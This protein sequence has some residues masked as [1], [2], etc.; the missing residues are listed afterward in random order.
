MANYY[1]SLGVSKG[2]SDK[3]IRQA[4]RKLARQYHPDLNPGDKEAEE[5]FKR[6]NEAHEI[7]SDPES[8]KKYDR[9]GDSW[10]HADQFG[11]GR[12]GGPSQWTYRSGDLG[13]GTSG[14]LDDIIGRFDNF[15]GPSGGRRRSA[16][17]RAEVQVTVSLE[18]AF[19]GTKRH[20]TVTSMDQARR[21]EVTIPPGVDT[22][23]VVNVS[24][25]D[26][27]RL[28]LKV[29]VTPHARF[30]RRGRDL[31]TEAEVAL[32]DA[33]LGAETEVQTLKGRVRL[34]VPARSQNGQRIRLAA[35]GM[36]KLGEPSVTGDLYVTVRPMLPKDLSEEEE[37]V[38]RQYK[39]LRSKRE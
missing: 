3:E 4:Y 30:E 17:A 15:G 9:H 37:E 10:K 21:I 14:T 27:T 8:R 16:R 2:A 22:G 23:S 12:G 7:L 35:Q 5:K 36:P 33:I 39:E 6:I 32:E 29:T 20:V 24:L 13:F 18:E 34:K 26:D 11:A 1:E 38:F 25:D 28:A 19:A 31:Y